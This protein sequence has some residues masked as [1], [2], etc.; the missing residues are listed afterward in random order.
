MRILF[1]L[2]CIGSL[3]LTGCAKDSI[4]LSTD[5][6]LIFGHFYGE[7]GGEQCIEIFKLENGRLYED[8]KDI[9]P[10]GNG[11]YEGDFKELSIDKYELV[12]GI[13]ADFPNDLLN[14]DN[15]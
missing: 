11:V 5:D 8:T 10:N 9:Y 15:G 2:G 14:I 6:Y 1:V 3:L 13:L 4:G 7:C 12:K